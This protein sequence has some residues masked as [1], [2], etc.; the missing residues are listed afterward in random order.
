MVAVQ[1]VMTDKPNDKQSQHHDELYD[2]AFTART[3][4][5]KL[6]R[7][8]QLLRWHLFFVSSQRVLKKIFAIGILSF[9]PFS[10]S[11][12]YLHNCVALTAFIENHIFQQ[13]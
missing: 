1:R 13:F 7:G 8:I 5:I 2:M 10:F 9:S 4:N 6:V 11:D 3:E 12:S